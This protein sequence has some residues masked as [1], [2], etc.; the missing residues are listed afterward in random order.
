MLIV[1][2]VL[3]IILMCVSVFEGS[4]GSVKPVLITP[5]TNL[6]IHTLGVSHGQSMEPF[7]HEGDVLLYQS[8]PFTDVKP[9]MVAVFKVEFYFIAHTVQSNNGAILKC[10]GENSDNVEYVSDTSYVGVLVK[11][12]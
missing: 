3:V 4:K 5:V 2:I 9:G 8:I 10:K 6:P 7:L 12:Q 1:A 11:K